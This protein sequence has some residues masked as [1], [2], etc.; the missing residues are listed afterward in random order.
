MKLNY[1][2]LFRYLL[3]QWLLTAKT[4]KKSLELYKRTISKIIE[5][6]LYLS[7]SRGLLYVTDYT[8]NWV[9]RRFEHLSCFLPGLLA[10]G[11]E[12]LPADALTD[13]ERQ[14]HRW[15]AQG[16]GEACATI[17]NDN[18]TGLGAEEI[19]KI[20]LLVEETWARGNRSLGLL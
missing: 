1:F 16:L 7:P 15:A 12:T 19:V 8:S 9:S 18:P 20:E 10:L 6:N 11:A 5:H 3:K 4:E 13:D 17:Y 14:L 2:Y